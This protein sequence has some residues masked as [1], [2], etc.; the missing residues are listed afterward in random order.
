M[1]S[2]SPSSRRTIST[3]GP[4]E[5]AR[6]TSA[7]TA[8]ARS[9]SSRTAAL[10]ATCSGWASPAGRVSGDSGNRVSPSTP[11]GSLLVA[12]TRTPGQRPR[13]SATS[14]AAASTTCSQLS[15]TS[16]QVASAS[17]SSTRARASR[18][19]R[20]PGCSSWAT[21]RTPRPSR[22]ASAMLSASLTGCQLHEP[23]TVG[24][25]GEEPGG[26]LGGQPR[27]P[28]APGA[29]ER[30]QPSGPEPLGDRPHLTLAAD[31]AG[32]RG[33]QV[34]PRR[35]SGALEAQHLEVLVL[36]GGGRVG[37]EGVDQQLAGALVGG[38]RVG[39]TVRR[40]QRVHQQQGE[41]LAR[42]VS[43]CQGLELRHDLGGP[44][45]P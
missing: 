1:A 9:S 14:D 3:T 37:A 42:R 43:R 10:A 44:A 28:G 25:V 4:M 15:T 17:V 21:S 23:D 5:V 22:A 30:H 38:Q 18:R 11:S 2:G 13:M 39:G 27:L 40:D 24:Y 32:H 41:V 45:Q 19:G 12:S 6:S 20:S 29:D 26:D 34:G 8:R 33:A 7:P 31:E 16:R 36:Q 35:R